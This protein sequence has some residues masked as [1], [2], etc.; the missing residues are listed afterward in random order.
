MLKNMFK[1]WTREAKQPVYEDVFGDIIWIQLTIRGISWRGHNSC[2][3]IAS[4]G[5]ALMNDDGCWNGHRRPTAS[6]QVW[7][8]Q[9]IHI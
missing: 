4:M 6:N 3:P 5:R 8:Y 1:Q 7:G 2:K 9:Q